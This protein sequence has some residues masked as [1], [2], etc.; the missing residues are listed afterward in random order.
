[1]LQSFESDV[2]IQCGVFSSFCLSFSS[3]VFDLPLLNLRT[4][5]QITLPKIPSDFIRPLI[6]ILLKILHTTNKCVDVENY[7]PIRQLFSFKTFLWSA[8]MQFQNTKSKNVT[9]RV[10]SGAAKIFIIKIV[11]NQTAEIESQRNKIGFLLLHWRII[12]NYW[13]LFVTMTF[14]S[15]IIC[16]RVALTMI[17]FWFQ[18]DFFFVLFAVAIWCLLIFRL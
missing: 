9:S 5:L 1:M 18:M 2:P 8:R 14:L 17:A 13:F 3:S 7:F 16:H 12:D 10:C 11:P 6:R 4:L 15:S